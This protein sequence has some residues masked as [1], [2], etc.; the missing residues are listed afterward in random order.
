MYSGF[1]CVVQH[2]SESIKSA[3]LP[4]FDSLVEKEKKEVKE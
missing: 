1:K 2:E 4:V 3:L